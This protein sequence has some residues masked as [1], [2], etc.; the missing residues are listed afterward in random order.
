MAT[1]LY[2]VQALRQ[3]EVAAQANLPA[4]ELM[5]R[6]GAAAAKLIHAQRQDARTLIVCGPGNN[7]GDG[8]VCA[9][10][11]KQLG[12]PV[13][14]VALAPPSTADA[15]AAAQRWNE[16]GGAVV[17][18]L[19]SAEHDV[20]VD[21]MFG[22]GM[23]RPL[24]DAYLDA[25]RWMSSRRQHVLAIDV[26]SGLD[27]DR[28]A[29]VGDV[30]GVHAHATLTFLGAKPGLFTHD[31]VDAAGVVHVDDLGIASPA[32]AGA[33]LEPSDFAPVLAPRPRNSHKGSYGN[34]LVVGGHVGMVGAALIAARAALR[35]GAGR[36]YV[37]CIG[38]PEMRLDPAQPELMFRRGADVVPVDALVI[39]CGLGA[40]AA[41]A[42]AL[43]FALLQPTPLVIDADALN[44]I[45]ADTALQRTLRAH[46][47][48]CVLTPHPLEAG[49][50]LGL[51]AREI[52]QD[53][54]RAACMLAD[55]FSCGV[56]LKGAGTVIAGASGD[57]WINPTGSPALATAG[58]GDALAGMIGA[59]IAQ[60]IT[61]AVAARA[62]V[63][64]H[65][66]AADEFSDEIG[67]TAAEIA[68]IAARILSRLRRGTVGA[69]ASRVQFDAAGAA[70]RDLRI[71][72]DEHQG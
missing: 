28:G 32:P 58:T 19:P 42:A 50:L 2:S 16:A 30:P 68:P 56:V 38:A 3:I 55:R 71:V 21:A 35:L 51:S 5:R 69:D 6:A 18:S 46:G 66:A 53:R 11:L 10:E 44:L 23:A 24:G 43:R 72:G 48:S 45:A 57:Y 64:L 17:P 1:R 37:D 34:V 49:R 13:T 7:G 61:P 41:A 14:L 63:W 4:G 29:W 26:P 9:A 67:L 27:A 52:Q 59:M 62:A 39:G 25:A 12:H 31:G 47:Q 60:Q 70:R 33:L 54:I 15:R 65:G 40:D 8:Y 36:V 20:I 22:I